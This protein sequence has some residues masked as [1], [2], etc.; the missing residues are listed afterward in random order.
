MSLSADNLTIVALATPP[1]R[2]SIA[3]VRLSGPQAFSAVRGL[4]PR[5]KSAESFQSNRVVLT[6]LYSRSGERLDQVTLVRYQKPHSYTGED[7]VEIFCH[8][9]R[10]IPNLIIEQLCA[11]GCR[12]AE[13][14]EFTQRALLH[15]KLDLIQAEA[16]AD[17]VE[18]ESPAYLHRALAHLEGAFSRR[19]GALREQL[20]H[21]CALLELGL[22]FSEE[23]VEFA[24]RAQIQRELLQLDE[25]I[26][27]LLKGFARGQALKE[28]WRI[29]IIGKPNVGKSSLMNALLKY[30]RVIVSAI[31][32]TTRDTIDERLFINGLLFR[33]IDTAGIREHARDLAGEIEKIGIERSRAAAQNADVIL[34]VTDDSKDGDEADRILAQECL[35]LKNKN[36]RGAVI[37]TRNKSDLP[38][39]AKPFLFDKETAHAIRVSALSGAGIDAL[40]HAIAGAVMPLSNL[41]G[42]EVQHINLRQKLCLEQARTALSGAL[43]SLEKNLSA[44]FITVDLREVIHQLGVLVGEVTT[45][46]VLGEIFSKFCIGK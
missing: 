38:A 18:A 12:L 13:P 44:E 23:D 27:H 14:G 24:D 16:V 9:G 41:S 40:E 6:W 15:G 19:L 30:D 28:G 36:G 7:V 29:A 20:L 32:G 1:G 17:L 42:A 34:F 43:S 4:L 10:L 37:H 31:P 21:A 22:D 39:A 8:G 45:E 46:D 5:D 33:L 2:G 3:C 26:A 35:D 11:Q 25:L